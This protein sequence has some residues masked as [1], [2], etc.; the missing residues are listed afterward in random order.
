MW[1]YSG[2]RRM[3]VV[4]RRPF[5]VPS[6][7]GATGSGLDMPCGISLPC[8]QGAITL[9][10]Q[11]TLVI[12]SVVETLLL[13]NPIPTAMSE[14]PGGGKLPDGLLQRVRQYHHKE[15]LPPEEYE[16]LTHL[17]TE[18]VNPG[19]YDKQVFIIGS[20]DDDEKARLMGLRHAI[21]T[22]ENA[23]Y[24]AFLMEDLPSGLHPIVSFQLIADYSDHIVGVCEHDRGGFQLEL[25]VIIALTRYFDRSHLLKRK[26]PNGQDREHFNWMLQVG[27]FEMFEYAG[28]LLEWRP[29]NY[30]SKCSEFIASL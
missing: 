9:V 7:A 27:V 10:S 30:E 11:T 18:V 21:N 19:I 17:V 1:I 2:M 12:T 25:G 8:N 15:T 24:R 3:S 16:A 5:A 26:Y 6:D 28:R 14:G 22:V 23:D 20:Y 4:H 29:E 13:P